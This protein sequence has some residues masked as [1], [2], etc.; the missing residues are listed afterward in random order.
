MG[1]PAVMLQPVVRG[2]A[3]CQR[4]HGEAQITPWPQCQCGCTRRLVEGTE[5]DQGVGGHDDIITGVVLLHV[6]G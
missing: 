2:L 3:L 4:F 6:R 5:L 1:I